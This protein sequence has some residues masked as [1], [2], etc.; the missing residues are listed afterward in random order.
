MQA[1]KYLLDLHVLFAPT[2]PTVADAEGEAGEEAD[3]LSLVLDD[4]TQY[5]CA[6]YIQAEIERFAELLEDDIAHAETPSKRGSDDEQ[7]SGDDED[8]NNDR[9][10]SKEKE[11]EKEKAGERKKSQKKEGIVMSSPHFPHR[12]ILVVVDTESRSWLEREYLFIDVISTF[13][14]AIRAGTISILHGSVLL[15]HYGRLGVAFDTCVKVVVE[16][17]RE[18]V[19]AGDNGEIMVTVVT[20]AIQ[21]VCQHPPLTSPFLT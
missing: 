10:K 19:L 6:G 2:Q 3:P 15:A 16:V 13:L 21:E 14:R 7:A 9:L 17:L 18:E 5:R 20:K 4:E 11:K 12:L 8:E 1:F